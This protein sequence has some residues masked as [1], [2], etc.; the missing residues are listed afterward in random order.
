MHW[1]PVAGWQGRC[2]PVRRSLRINGTAQ[3]TRDPDLLAMLAVI[4]RQPTVAIV[5]AV[6]EVFLHCAKTFRR[7]N[8]WDPTAL[9]D[10]HEMPSLVTMILD[11]TTGAPD[12][13]AQLQKNDA[14]LEEA[15][16][17][18]MY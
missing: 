11:Q 12:D 13:P 16:R 1:N 18:S 10:R 4:E 8:L 2:Q 17:T 5:V 14:D 3:I 6:K 9:Q 7:S 15:Y